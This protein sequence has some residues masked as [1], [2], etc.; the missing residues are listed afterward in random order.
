MS[1]NVQDAQDAQDAP[2]H[3]DKLRLDAAYVVVQDVKSARE[4][5]STIFDRSPVIAALAM[6][7]R[8]NRVAILNPG[9]PVIALRSAARRKRGP[10]HSAP[11]S[12]LSI[13][14]TRS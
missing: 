9:A 7:S 10:P 12:E 6:E 11:Q 3:E 8:S 13:S 14:Q 5:Y 2:I 4:L 1:S